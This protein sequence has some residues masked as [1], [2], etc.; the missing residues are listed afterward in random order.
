VFPNSENKRWSKNVSEAFIFCSPK[1]PA[2]IEY[3]KETKKFT[4]TIPF[5]QDGSTSGATEGIGNLYSYVCGKQSI[6]E[7]SPELKFSEIVIEKPTD[8][9]KY[10]SIN[11]ESKEEN[12]IA[13]GDSTTPKVTRNK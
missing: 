4:G 11:A 13:Q 12:G 6:F 10:P 3:N 5:N 7:I 8:I 2:Y 1:L 9:F